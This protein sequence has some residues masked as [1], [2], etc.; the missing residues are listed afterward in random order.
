MI[1]IS[2]L[3]FRRIGRESDGLL[4]ARRT[5]RRWTPARRPTSKTAAEGRRVVT[6]WNVTRTATLR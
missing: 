5:S 3:L 2:K 6:V 1:I 4:Y